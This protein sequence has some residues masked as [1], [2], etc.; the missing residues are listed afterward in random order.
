M[1]LKASQIELRHDQ[2]RMPAGKERGQAMKKFAGISVTLI[3]M[4]FLVGLIAGCGSSSNSG[5]ASRKH[6]RIVE[7]E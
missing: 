3:V 6:N 2:E 7:F 1:A 5:K 4:V